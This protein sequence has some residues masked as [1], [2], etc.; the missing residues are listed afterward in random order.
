MTD[1]EFSTARLD[2][3]TEALDSPS[4]EREWQNITFKVP[5][6][7]VTLFNMTLSAYKAMLETDKDFPALEA[8]ILEAYN[9]LPAEIHRGL[10][11]SDA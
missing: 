4:P 2:R 1:W 9:S 11:G 5:Q 10:G 3:L 6:N 8:M 7:F